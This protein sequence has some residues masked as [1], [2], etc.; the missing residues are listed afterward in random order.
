ML[1][2]QQF[3]NV[4][5]EINFL[6]HHGYHI[7]RKDMPQIT[8]DNREA[9]LKHLD[10]NNIKHETKDIQLKDY[11]ITQGE[12]DNNKVMSLLDKDTDN[13]PILVS[14][15]NYV[16][17]GHHRYISNYI[18]DKDDTMKATIIDLPIVGVLK[19]THEF[20]NKKEDPQ[21]N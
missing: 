16:L 14:S 2:F 17:D 12:I 13:N 11:K 19:L 4:R 20:L 7:P 10:D 8:K 9:F 3:N 21:N 5:D 15:D 6:I 18:K 1:G